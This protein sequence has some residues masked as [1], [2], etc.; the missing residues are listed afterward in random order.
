MELAQFQIAF[1]IRPDYLALSAPAFR[2]Y[3]AFVL[4]TVKH[5]LGR[6]GLA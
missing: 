1:Q 6:K 5:R 3:L 4:L 2:S